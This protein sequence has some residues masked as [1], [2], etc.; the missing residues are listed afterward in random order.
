MKMT[1]SK[2]DDNHGDAF[3]FEFE[4]REVA[5]SFLDTFSFNCKQD[6]HVILRKEEHHGDS[7]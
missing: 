6:I 5:F 2:N 3:D 1:I 4:E 7:V